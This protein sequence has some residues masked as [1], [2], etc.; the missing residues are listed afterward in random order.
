MLL[1]LVERGARI[2]GVEPSCL[3]TRSDEM[4]VLKLGPATETRA[5]P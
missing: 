3:L 4:Q 1:P 5:L 2:A